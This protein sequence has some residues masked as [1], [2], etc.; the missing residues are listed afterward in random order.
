[1]KGNEEDDG[2]V[3]FKERVNDTTIPESS[4]H[5]SWLAPGLTLGRGGG[6]RIKNIHKIISVLITAFSTF[7]NKEIV[8]GFLI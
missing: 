4:H 1:M 2:E 8:L 7:F 6:R 5:T 3:Y